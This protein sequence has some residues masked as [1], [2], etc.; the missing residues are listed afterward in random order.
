MLAVMVV[1]ATS[2]F[3][4]E[5]QPRIL[6]S[7]PNYNFGRIFEAEKYS[8]VFEV[9]NTGEALLKIERVKPG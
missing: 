7:N 9:K 8:H 2:V 6:I 5:P 1:V 3:G 4:A